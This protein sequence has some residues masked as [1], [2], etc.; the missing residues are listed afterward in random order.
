[1]GRS[2]PCVP[3]H[4]PFQHPQRRSHHT[5]LSTRSTRTRQQ[6]PHSAESPQPP[7]L[8]PPPTLTGQGPGRSP[9]PK[10]TRATAIEA[11]H[12]EDT[13]PPPVDVCTPHARSTP[14]G[15]VPAYR[16]LQHHRLSPIRGTDFNLI[17]GHRGIPFPPAAPC[18]DDPSQM[19]STCAHSACSQH[20]CVRT[21]TDLKI[22]SCKAVRGQGGPRYVCFWYLVLVVGNKA[23]AGLSHMGGLPRHCCFEERGLR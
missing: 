4:T 5:F 19:S 21:I 2:Q 20:T 23:E 11:L 14:L 13:P 9:A 3:R 12:R 7:F 18:P 15:N 17:I 16:S 6:I 22:P 8:S 10:P 1:M